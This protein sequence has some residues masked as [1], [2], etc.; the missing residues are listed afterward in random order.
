MNKKTVANNV[1]IAKF[2]GYYSE[3][4]FPED[5]FWDFGGFDG[6]SVK[7]NDLDYHIDWNSLMSVIEKI[8]KHLF[9][10]SI[11][12]GQMYHRFEIHQHPQLPLDI[13]INPFKTIESK[14]KQNK[15]KATYK[16]V[17]KFIKWYNKNKKS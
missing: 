8:E 13:W 6:H 10:T 5:L 14:D 4:E 3:P 7:I 16:G 1:L 2:Q 9:V 17:V 11:Q 15:L 12:Y